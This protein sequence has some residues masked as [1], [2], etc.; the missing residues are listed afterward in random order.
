MSYA[1]LSATEL[2]AYFARI[3]FTG[4]SHADLATLRKLHHLHPLALTF[5]NLDSWCGLTPA[6]TEHAVFDKLVAGGRGGYCF[7]HNQLFMRVL[8]TLGFNVQGLS[9]RV[10][11]PDVALPRTHKVLL[12]QLDNEQWL[13][14]VGFGGMTMTAPLRLATEGPQATSHEPWQLQRS[15][16]S[17]LVS[18][19]VQD[20]WSPKFRFS[21]ETQTPSDYELANWYVATYPTSRFKHDL[22]AARVD[23][24]SRHALLNNRYMHHRLDQ[25]SLQ[26]D[27]QSAAEMSALLQ[28]VFGLNIDSIP[29]LP[30]RLATLFSSR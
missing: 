21:L 25:P 9:A 27:V 12:V 7:E 17:Y 14:D 8:L 10:I 30:A 28:T 19:W 6:L 23:R 2:S 4:E 1:P 15:D 13:V 18:A 5:E 20:S 16:H 3:G 22:I 24:D 11:V 26:T 29:A